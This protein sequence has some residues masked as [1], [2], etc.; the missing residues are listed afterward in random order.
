MNDKSFSISVILPTL[1]EADNLKVLIPDISKRIESLNISNYEIIVVD[2]SSVDDTYGVISN[3]IENKYKIKFI[4]RESK[5][6]IF[7]PLMS[8]FKLSPIQI[9]FLPFKLLN[10]FS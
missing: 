5:F 10:A 3:M 8:V 6:C 2:D 4:K 7:A 9:T 1:N